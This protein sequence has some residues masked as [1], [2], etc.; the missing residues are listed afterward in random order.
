MTF[1]HEEVLVHLAP[2]NINAKIKYK[3]VSKLTDFICVTY[4]YT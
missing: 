3:Y 1:L 2:G 4:D